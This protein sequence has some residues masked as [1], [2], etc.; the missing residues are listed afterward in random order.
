MGELY[1]T[2]EITKEITYIEVWLPITSSGNPD[3]G[4]KEGLRTGTKTQPSFL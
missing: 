1:F 4:R 2:K 3:G